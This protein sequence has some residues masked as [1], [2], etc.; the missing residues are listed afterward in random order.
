MSYLDE[1]IVKLREEQEQRE[2]EWKVDLSKEQI[3]Y[4]ETYQFVLTQFFEDCLELMI[5]QEFIPMPEEQVENKYKMEQKPQV[6]MTNQNYRIDITLNL[7]EE[8]ITI[9]QIPL[10][11]QKLKNTIN[12]VY[13]ATMFFEEEQKEVNNTSVAYMDFK[14][15]SLGGPI[16]NVMFVSKISNRL[17]V[18]TFNCPFTD[19]EQWRPVVVEMLE[20]IQDS[21]QEEKGT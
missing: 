1:A 11:L 14:S 19:W 10:C 6:I 12:E 3:I 9:E 13:P 16:Y 5:P 4:G 7:L 8:T 20:T 15:F 18:G 2:R 17:L 21:S